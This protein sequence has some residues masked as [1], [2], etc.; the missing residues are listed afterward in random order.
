MIDLTWFHEAVSFLKNQPNV[1]ADE[2]IEKGFAYGA[3]LSFGLAS[4]YPEMFSAV[5]AWTPNVFV[6][7][8]VLRVARSMGT[9]ELEKNF[10]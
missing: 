8:G 2:I 9:L 6:S 1:C 3:V 10:E 5:A 4:Q 7:R